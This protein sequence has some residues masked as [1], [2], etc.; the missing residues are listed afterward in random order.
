MS[1][2][3]PQHGVA[4]T[5]GGSAGHSVT[6]SRGADK[7]DRLEAGTQH[8][9]LLSPPA[10]AG[11]EHGLPSLEGPHEGGCTDV[12]SC[13]ETAMCITEKSVTLIVSLR[14]TV[15]WNQTK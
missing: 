10:S 4:I 11:A 9:A 12:Q 13:P 5:H 1:F 8:S 6:A 14:K 7:G 15:I 2:Q 3:N